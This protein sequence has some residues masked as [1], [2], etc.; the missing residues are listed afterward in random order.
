MAAIYIGI[1][2][3]VGQ[4]REARAI[5]RFGEAIPNLEVTTTG[6]WRKYGVFSEASPGGL[7]GKSATI[8]LKCPYK[9]RNT[10]LA[11]V[12]KNIKAYVIYKEL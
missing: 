4:E 12:L 11:E 8:E 2:H 5:E 10:S 7:C 6:L 3:T 1:S 9:Y